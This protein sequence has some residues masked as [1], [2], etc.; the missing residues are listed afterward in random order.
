MIQQFE[1]G[2]DY[3]ATA[4]PGA[5]QRI[6][7]PITVHAVQLSLSRPQSTRQKSSARAAL[8]DVGNVRFIVSAFADPDAQYRP[9][10]TVGVTTATPGP[11]V[12]SGVLQRGFMRA[13]TT[14]L[15]RD[16][17]SCPL[18]S[19]CWWECLLAESAARVHHWRAAS[20]LSYCAGSPDGH[21]ASASYAF[22]GE[23]PGVMAFKTPPACATRASTAYVRRK[24]KGFSGHADRRC[25]CPPARPLVGQSFKRCA[26]LLQCRQG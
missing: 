24:V 12:S 21:A 19:M 17:Y 6:C 7:V 18:I 16:S 20:A 5:A 23:E 13:V 4:I 26:V 2:A 11:A 3:A 14:M 9:A 10:A 1:C 15:R 8:P 25:R 22:H